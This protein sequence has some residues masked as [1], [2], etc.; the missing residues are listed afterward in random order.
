ML[1]LRCKELLEIYPLNMQSLLT[2]LREATASSHDTLDK[3]FGSLDL[4]V[5]EE[6]VRFLCGH[7]I[8][9]RPL[10][11]TFRSFVEN[12][13]GV[14]CPDYPVML[15]DDLAALGVDAADLPAVEVPSTLTPLAT[16]YVVAGSR[17]GLA[18][19]RK[20]GYWGQAHALPSAYMEDNAGQAI[21]KDAVARLKSEVSDKS[22]LDREGAA[23][24][25]AFGTFRD[26]FAAS[27]T[28]SVK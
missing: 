28:E 11:A 22:V 13:L 3:A 6:Y 8:G 20:K 15:H 19:I 2:S 23:A 18:V 25:A 17:L 16:G 10:F 24:I 5:H 12:D 1:R 14:A 21:W 7:A 4:T 9:I 26:A 27:M